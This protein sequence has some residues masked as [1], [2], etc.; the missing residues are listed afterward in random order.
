MAQSQQRS[1]NKGTGKKKAAKSL[2]EKRKDKQA[3][4]AANNSRGW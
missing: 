1:G 3:K 2:M 4:Q